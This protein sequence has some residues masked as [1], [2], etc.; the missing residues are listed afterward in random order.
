MQR[1]R[2]M[3]IV[4]P[5][6][7]PSH[8]PRRE[9]QIL[10]HQLRSLRRRGPAQRS[11]T[12]L[13]CRA[14]ANPC[15]CW[16]SLQI[17]PGGHH[18]L[19]RRDHRIDTFPGQRRN[20]HRRKAANLNRSIQTP[21]IALI[22]HRNGLVVQQRHRQPVHRRPDA[23]V[24]HRQGQIRVLRPHPC[25]PHPFLFHLLAGVPQPRGVG[26]HHRKA[27]DVQRHFDNVPGGTGLRRDDRRLS[28]G[29]DVE[30]A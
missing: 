25:P 2:P 26:N 28:S 15:Q 10:R 11:A 14:V 29:D 6:G 20:C 7:D 3:R 9:P 21:Q 16:R 30:K 18:P 19:H 23:T 1:A 12:V 17:K 24:E 5:P 4:H 27:A 13:Q 22:D 8:R